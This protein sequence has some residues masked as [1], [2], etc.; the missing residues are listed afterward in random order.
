M[1]IRLLIKIQ[2]N[3]VFRYARD[4]ALVLECLV[5][6]DEKDSTSIAD[7][8]ARLIDRSNGKGFDPNFNLKELKIGIPVEYKQ[9]FLG[10]Q[11]KDGEEILNVWNQIVKLFEDNG[12]AIKDVSLPR[13]KYVGATYMVINSTEVA[14]NFSCYDGI[15]FGHRANEYD[16]TDGKQLKQQEAKF[17]TA[18]QLSQE[19]RSVFG[20]NVKSRIIAG[21]YFLL[22]SNQEKYLKQ[23]LKVRRLICQ[24]YQNVFKGFDHDV[25][26]VK[27]LR[28]NYRNNHTTIR[29][30]VKNMNVDIGVHNHDTNLEVDDDDDGRVDFILTP[31]TIRSAVTISEWR[32]KRDNQQQAMKEDYLT[33]GANLAGIPAVTFPVTL[34]EK[35]LPLSLQLVGNHF[36]DFRLLSVADQIQ[37]MINFPFLS[38]GNGTR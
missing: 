6:H 15:E 2:N 14:S 1:I 20:T 23:A 31:A 38:F 5:G 27:E 34:S 37:Q 36:T 16:N 22:T 24:D 29:D 17:K 13:S 26:Q 7:G 11:S 4:A 35:G 28:V 3:N 19:T 21:N 32:K 18:G 33:T 25:A 9:E 8:M 30:S 10:D 12:S